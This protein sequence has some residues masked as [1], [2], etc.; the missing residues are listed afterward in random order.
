M[1][2]I[3]VKNSMG[4]DNGQCNGNCIYNGDSISVIR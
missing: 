2:V 3:I 1:W 4:N